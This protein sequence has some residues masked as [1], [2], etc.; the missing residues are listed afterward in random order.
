M[1]TIN[2]KTE[3]PSCVLICGNT[4]LLEMNTMKMVSSHYKLVVCGN[5]SLAPETGRKLP[6]NV[7]L[8]PHQP[9]SGEFAHVMNSYTPDVVWYF[10]GYVDNGDG[11]DEEVKLISGLMEQCR[12]H[13]VSKLIVV[14]PV[15]SLF[16]D[17][18]I[19]GDERP[20]KLESGF[21]KAFRCAQMEDLIHYYA[22]RYELKTVTV[23][24]PFLSSERNRGTWLGKQFNLLDKQNRIVLPA[25]EDQPIE[26]ISLRNLTELLIS[27]TEETLDESGVYAVLSG[28]GHTWRELGS[29][30]AECNPALRI[31]YA[32]EA[33]SSP[34]A[35]IQAAA[36]SKGKSVRREYG[37]VP[38]DDVV[39]DLKTAY[40]NYKEV[41][42]DKSSILQRF[43]GLLSRLPSW[44][45]QA[46]EL[47]VLFGLMQLLLRY[48]SDS[49]YFRYVDLRL[50][51]V[52][53]FG[54]SYGM[55]TGIVAGLLSCVSLYIAYISTG[56]T[57]IMLF[58][59]VD[60]WLPFAIYLM[61]GAITGY[62]KGARRL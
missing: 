10:S 28:F 35:R 58:Y 16:V 45:N 41:N 19:T 17:S 21:P 29:A 9:A 46:I 13:E 14:S 49:I 47:P 1:N 31:E 7:H 44:L 62:I 34:H 5:L 15:N 57:G 8:Y 37:F 38:M 39:S 36:A 52:V 53:I 60:F 25:R 59:N 2:D 50:F 3:H 24:L 32:P 54:C 18:A 11:L 33:D 12:L 61:T 22:R 27:I 30:L 6:R 43:Q 51:F 42:S 26:L 55:I 20:G 23:Q 4:E 40:A 48:T 56:V